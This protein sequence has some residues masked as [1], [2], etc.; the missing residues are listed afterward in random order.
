[1]IPLQWFADG[2]HLSL[3]ACGRAWTPREGGFLFREDSG[4]TSGIVAQGVANH[5]SDW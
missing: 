2:D 5:V 4:R 3:K 1:M